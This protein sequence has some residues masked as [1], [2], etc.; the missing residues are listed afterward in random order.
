MKLITIKKESASTKFDLPI[1]LSYEDD[2]T[3]E[4]VK[5]IKEFTDLLGLKQIKKM[6]KLFDKF[7]AHNKTLEVP[8]KNHLGKEVNNY[9]AVNRS[10]VFLDTIIQ[11]VQALSWID[12]DQGSRLKY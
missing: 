9:L 10:E 2:L 4:Q 12:P 3:S 7:S 8:Y 11:V 1:T 6:R 5:F